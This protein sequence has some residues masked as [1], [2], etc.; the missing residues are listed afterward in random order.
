MISAET[1]IRD[2]VREKLAG[3]KVDVVA[4]VD[5]LLLLTE[6][7]SSLHCTRVEDRAL[8]F[9]LADGTSF[10]VD[11]D[12]P[13][14]KLR[15]ACARLGVL[16]GE[17]A[18]GIYPLYG[19]E[20]FIARPGADETLNGGPA[21]KVRFRNTPSAHEFTMMASSQATLSSDSAPQGAASA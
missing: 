15:M 10:E 1:V 8:R 19:G 11:L 6:E 17:D 21:V 16:C 5:R 20:G 3:R 4:F 7:V 9:E 12:S 2:L 14:G 13:R 18:E